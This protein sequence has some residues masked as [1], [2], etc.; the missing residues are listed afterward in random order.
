MEL[1]DRDYLDMEVPAFLRFGDGLM[2]E[3][4]FGL[5]RGWIDCRVSLEGEYPRVEFSW[6]GA[7]E[8]EPVTGRG[9]AE[10]REG[11]LEGR[12]YIHRGTDSSFIAKSR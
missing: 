9:W 7:D 1:W 11:R 4:Q 12:I 6:E 2:G 5:V 3:F 8:L 10:L